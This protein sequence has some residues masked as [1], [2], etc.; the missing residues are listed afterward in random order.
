MFY[1]QFF[2]VRPFFRNFRK[3]EIDSLDLPFFRLI[4]SCW[5]RTL[6]TPIKKEAIVKK[7]M[8]CFV[9]IRFFLRSEKLQFFGTAILCLHFDDMGYV[10]VKGHSVVVMNERLFWYTC[11][12]NPR[13]E[14][15][16]W[17]VSV[18]AFFKFIDEFMKWM[19]WLKRWW[20]FLCWRHFTISKQ[21]LKKLQF[22]IY[23]LT[24]FILSKNS[25]SNFALVRCTSYAF[26]RRSSWNI[27]AQIVILY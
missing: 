4:S 9:Q 6:P 14:Q 17:H 25:V 18:L 20:A 5:R 1:M 15:L 26:Q 10:Q 7:C 12:E 13:S 8:R 19:V 22:Q 27:T 21:H 2:L 16:F 11:I 3:K 23:S 24:T